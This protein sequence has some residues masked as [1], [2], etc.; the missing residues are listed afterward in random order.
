M[1]RFDRRRLLTSSAG[2]EGAGGAGRRFGAGGAGPSATVATPAGPS[3]RPAAR[4]SPSGASPASPPFSPLGRSPE[5]WRRLRE[6]HDAAAAPVMDVAIDLVA[7]GLYIGNVRG[8]KRS[9]RLQAEGVTHILNCSPMV[10]CFHRD[11]FRYLELEVYDDSDE[12]IAQHFE[13]AIAFVREG[14]AAGGVFV[15]CFAGT[16]RSAA[17]VAAYLIREMALDLGEALATIK[18]ARASVRPNAGFMEQLGRWARD[19]AERRGGAGEAPGGPPGRRAPARAGG[20][21]GSP[22]SRSRTWPGRRT[23]ARAPAP[24][25]R[26]GRRLPRP[27]RARPSGRGAGARPPGPP[28][29]PTWSSP[30]PLPV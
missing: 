2:D 28:P 10:P 16:S 1:K 12:D 23:R 20:G 19:D 13:A 9:K 29:R 21:R 27:A 7:P 3:G 22:S 30:A 18:R 26:P 17:L 6:S 15:H 5:G 24:A 14:R 8:A 11:K 25:R 4:W